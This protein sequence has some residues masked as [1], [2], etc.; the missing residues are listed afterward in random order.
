M[1][2]YRHGWRPTRAAQ[3]PLSGMP[4]EAERGCSRRAAAASSAGSS[5][6][7][8]TATV[9]T[10]TAVAMPIRPTNGMPVASSP[11]IATTTIAPAVSTETPAVAF[12]WP[13]AVTAS[14]PAASRSR[15]RAVTSSA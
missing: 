3:R 7:A 8:P 9:A 1:S 14:S 15:K 2:A 5:V 12:A 6:T 4:A 10:T 13:A 11:E